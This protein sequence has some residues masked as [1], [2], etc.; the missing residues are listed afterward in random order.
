MEPRRHVTLD[1]VLGVT[2][3][4]LILLFPSVVLAESTNGDIDA[5]PFSRPGIRPGE[6]RSNGL[7]DINFTA[8]L[9]PANPGKVIW[10]VGPIALFPTATDDDLGNDK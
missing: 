3:V 9:S 1:I 7:G 6:D 4:A 10:G 2:T 5:A 8:F